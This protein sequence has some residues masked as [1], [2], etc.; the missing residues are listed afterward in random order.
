M[1][2]TLFLFVGLQHPIPPNPVNYADRRL[3]ELERGLAELDEAADPVA[4]FL[5]TEEIYFL[6]HES[7]YQE[8]IR[9]LIETAY[10]RA[11]HPE[12]KAELGFILARL[13]RQLGH[14]DAVARL[15][16]ELGYV[17]AWNVRG[18]LDPTVPEDIV[19]LVRKKHVPGRHREV[20]WQEVRAY[21][22]DD[23]F[24]TGM[25]QYGYFDADAIVFP[26]QMVGTLFT[27]WFFADREKTF[28]LGLGWS[29][30]LGVWVD[31]TRI[32]HE[33][34]DQV[35]HPDQAS[36][37]FSVPKGWHRLTLYT[38]T[39]TELN[40]LGFFARI[41]DDRGQPPPFR[42][43]LQRRTPRKK[44]RILPA[45][46]PDLLSLAADKSAYALGSLLLAKEI[47]SLDP[48]GKPIDHLVRAQEEHPTIRVTE[49][50][51]SLTTDPNQ[52]WG[53]V[54]RFL[55][56][57]P[58]SA[59]GY[60]QLGQ[61]ALSQS[62]FWEARHYADKAKE[63]QADY[64]PA[65]VLKNNT[66]AQLRLDG[67]A[68]RNTQALFDRYPDVPWLEMDLCD[69]YWEMDFRQKAEALLEDII[70]IRHGLVKYTE[71][72]LT[73]L[74]AR[75]DSDA[76]DAFYRELLQ[77]APYSI[78]LVLDYSAFLSA[79]R[80]FD[81]A[82]SLLKRYLAQASENPFLLEALG[83]VY[84]QQGKP[85]AQTL[86]AEA[87]RIRP[88]NPNLEKR[89]KLAAASTDAFYDPFRIEDLPQ[90]PPLERAPV[91]ID[92]DN[93]VRKISPDGQSSVFHQIQYEIVDE[94]GAQA[95]PGFSFS[96]AP[97][98]QKAELIKAEVI[99]GDQKILI[100]ET[101]RSRISEP[102]YRTYYD[103]VAFQIA[104]P[105]LQ[106]GDRVL[107]E[108]RIDDMETYNLF[109]EYFG[110]MSYFAAE[111]PIH[112]V[113]Y[114]LL[115]PKGHEIHTRVANMEPTFNQFTWNDYD[116]FQWQL[117]QVASFEAERR[118]PGLQMFLPYVCISTFDDWQELAT[119]YSQL[120]ARQLELSSE[121]KKLVDDL[122]RDAP[123]R[124]SRVKKIH[125]YVISNTR[126]V[127][128]EFGV[129]GYKPYDVNQVCS[130][131]FGDC[132]DKA[133]LMIAMLRYAGID[134]DFAM[135]RT[136]D[137]GDI[138]PDPAAL[139]YF[140]HAIAYIPEFDLFLDGTA[141]FS[142]LSEL[143]EMDQGAQAF[144]VDEKG[145]GKLMRIPFS[146]DNRRDFTL[147][148]R[149]DPSGDV[150]VSGRLFHQGFQVPE[151]RQ[152]LSIE[153]KL[154]Q[155]LQN[156]VSR[157]L[158]GLEVAHVERSGFQLDEPI[159]LVFQGLSNQVFQKTSTAFR[160]P[161]S[162]LNQP[163]LQTF[164]PTA[165]RLFPV[166][167]GLPRAHRVSVRVIVPDGYHVGPLPESLHRQNEHL[168]LAIEIQ[169]DAPDRVEM[170][171]V[172]VIKSPRIP[173]ADYAE[174]RGFFLD[175]DRALA[176]S[177]DIIED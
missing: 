101:G 161:L 38:Q 43:D 118:M 57:N 66:F 94:Q 81:E 105:R 87:L 62:R 104:F 143:P 157:A 41:T 155:N 113:A 138:E 6:N 82:A 16:H 59:W 50:L 111:Y 56:A 109:G 67:L 130:R 126:Y 34:R 23:F 165:D 115:V 80:K 28:R 139:I 162:V 48:Y 58:N 134:A 166:E 171:Y 12:L 78:S 173:L 53:Y 77:D 117:D 112:R 37:T 71:R 116:V 122:I 68:L 47:H 19:D 31:R 76:L 125:D 154:D 89:L 64:W 20:A 131:Q 73:L 167:M 40:H 97:L 110:D 123:D 25:G 11:R 168:D 36:L 24:G 13:Y 133:S 96:Y 51:T 170:T 147:E 63:C 83:M 103:L 7:R 119:W 159:E 174:L 74:K 164:A 136:Y 148:F 142:G 176:Q 141:E 55:K 127:A 30:E 175:H 102:E 15:I 14:Y 120:I 95:L 99:R 17:A 108:Y 149:L 88:Q 129:H 44:P 152:Y 4:S 106:P 151:L 128:L 153:A 132:K 18:P 169:S 114:T 163:L 46:Q 52:R 156:L 92:F 32:F 45:K 150:A 90:V 177:L 35:P 135:V 9:Q 144:V 145:H 137:K 2:I 79:N 49:K 160:L 91:I 39:S 140:N 100:T 70:R 5:L 3:L 10:D 93:T 54:Q 158:P 65:D 1:F 98:R 72:K 124:L 21:G 107:L 42:A 85:E 75:R 121:T 146:Q 8:H 26:N 60:T 172:L 29:H 84:L 86:F 61:I 27:T 22:E 69:L 33:I